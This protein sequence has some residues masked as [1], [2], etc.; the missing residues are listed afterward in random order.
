MQGLLKE[1][2]IQILIYLVWEAG[3]SGTH[4]KNPSLAVD[5]LSAN[6][7]NS[8]YPLL[9]Q[10]PPPYFLGN[11]NALDGRQNLRSTGA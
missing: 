7:G 10:R 8:S 6:V 4:R 1:E 2:Q 9:P 5:L 11:F 3:I